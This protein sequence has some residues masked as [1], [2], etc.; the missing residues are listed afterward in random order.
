MGTVRFR[1]RYQI[2]GDYKIRNTERF[3]ASVKRKTTID[4]KVSKNSAF[5]PTVTFQRGKFYI[6]T[7]TCEIALTPKQFMDLEDFIVNA[8]KLYIEFDI[9][10]ITSEGGGGDGTIEYYRYEVELKDFPQM[11]DNGRF[12]AD[13][14]TFEFKSAYINKLSYA[15]P[16]MMEGYGS[17]YGICYGWS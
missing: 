2:N 15:D 16:D 4:Y 14:Y 10:N 11:T 17:E 8:E 12:F 5:D 6:A 3:D 9:A 7:F 13:I 1:D